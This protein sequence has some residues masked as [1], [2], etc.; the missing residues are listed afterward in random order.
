MRT[1]C[2]QAPNERAH[3][4]SER[5]PVMRRD[6]APVL[7]ALIPPEETRQVVAARL[8]FAS[9]LVEQPLNRPRPN[10]YGELSAGVTASLH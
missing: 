2:Q 6:W 8:E 5:T 10:A 1:G 7:L 4:A 9:R 3:S